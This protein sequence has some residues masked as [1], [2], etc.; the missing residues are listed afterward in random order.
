MVMARAIKEGVVNE[1]NPIISVFLREYFRK[2]CESLQAA[3]RILPNKFV[4]CFA[5]KANPC[6]AVLKEVIS[7]GLGCECASIAEVLMSLQNG[8]PNE[9]IIYDSPVKLKRDL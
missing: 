6:P 8:C 9:R 1:E 2:Q 3:V 4:N 7:S 5:V